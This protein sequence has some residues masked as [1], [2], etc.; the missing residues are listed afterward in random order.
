MS[1]SGHVGTAPPCSAV[2]TFCIASRPSTTA[3]SSCVWHT[4]SKQ[5]WWLLIFETYLLPLYRVNRQHE[6]VLDVQIFCFRVTYCM[7]QPL[8]HVLEGRSLCIAATSTGRS[9]CYVVSGQKK[10]RWC[11]IDISGQFLEKRHGHASCAVER[12]LI[13]KFWVW[14]G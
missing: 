9:L 13:V 4:S 2:I 14:I 6:R 3:S 11:R 5:V 1:Q 7:S 8:G 12:D 10:G